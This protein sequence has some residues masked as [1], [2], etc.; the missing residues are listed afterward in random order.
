MAVDQLAPGDPPPLELVDS[1]RLTGPN[2]LWDRPGAVLDVELAP[3]ADAALLDRAVERWSAAARDILDA[4]GWGDETTCHRRFPRGA[5]LAISAP[6]DALYAATEVNEQAWEATLDTLTGRPPQASLERDAA[7]LREAIREEGNPPLL[8]L[9]AAARERGLLFLSDDEHASVGSGTGVATWPVREIPAPAA[10]EWEARHDVPVA[11]VTGTNG[12]TT[13]VRLIAAMARAAGR[14]PGLCSTDGI[15]AGDAVVD[16]GDWSGPGGARAVLRH[17]EV[18]LAVLE[19][20]RGGMLRRGLGTDRADVAVITNVADDH[21]GE[22][23]V[24][25]LAALAEVK[26]IVARVARRLALNADDPVLAAAA[27]RHGL[28][29]VWF[30]LDAASPLAAGALARGGA[31]FRLEGDELVRRGAESERTVLARASQMPLAFGGA[32]RH[33]LANALAAC[34]AADALGLPDDAVRA[35]LAS[36]GADP[37]D[38]P[39]RLNRYRLGEVDVLVD[40]AHNPHGLDALLAT[41]RGL[42]RGRL[43]VVLGQA[44]D[45]SDDAIRDLARTVARFR[46]D[47]CVVKSLPE[48]RRGRS[49][50]EVESLIE[51]ELVRRGVPPAA[52]ERAEGE[53]VALERSLAWARPGDL[54]LQITHAHRDEVV[55]RLRELGAAPST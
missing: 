28:E 6:V 11:L 38:N 4:V 19:A 51:E 3:N 42:A 54:V 44:G 36:F 47:H 53:L 43:S 33:N 9:R 22:F 29:P 2:L 30:T 20:A 40:F 26:L 7:R 14:R 41:A 23:G 52:I 21:L 15:R 12:K 39:G 17:P 45:R 55:A 34:A 5:S 18:E 31:A 1:R 13:T 27:V 25:D 35:A 32:A 48:Y 16:A 50:G 10:V 46:P 24:H 8:A 37:V 49:E